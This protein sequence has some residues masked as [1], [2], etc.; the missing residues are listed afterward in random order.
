[1]PPPPVQCII[2]LLCSCLRYHNFRQ[3]G[4]YKNRE[5]ESVSEHDSTCLC[6]TDNA[7]LD[8]KGF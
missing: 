3:K 7:C 8:K 2:A 4:I 1:M 5:T 6:I